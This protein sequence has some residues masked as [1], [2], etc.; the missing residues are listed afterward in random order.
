M[1]VKIEGRQVDIGN[2]LRE[3]IQKR[4]DSLDSRFGPITHAR[5]SIEVKPHKNEQRAETTAVVNV[6]GST[7]TASRESGTV[8]A[9][10]NETIDVLTEE[11]QQWAEKHRKTF[12]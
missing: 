10:V 11:L 2:E 5:M 6:A 1:E 8:L 12:R 9:S 4:M 3:R 7:I